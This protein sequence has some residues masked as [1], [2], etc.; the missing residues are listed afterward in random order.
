[1][2]GMQAQ[3]IPE[4]SVWVQR[5]REDACDMILAYKVLHTNLSLDE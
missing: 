5:E 1:M 3:M 2:D 4:K